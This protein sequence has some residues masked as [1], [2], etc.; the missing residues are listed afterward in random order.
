MKN[1]PI[2]RDLE[3][4]SG[5]TW[6]ALAE[7]EPKLGELLWAARQAG[8]TC[9]CWADVDRAFA[10][11]LNALPEMVGL[12]GK[13]YRHPVLGQLPAYYVAYWRLYDAVAGL[14]PGRVGGAEEA[15]A[16][17]CGETVA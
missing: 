1:Y 15:P 4:L 12:T 2:Y 8:I 17:Q 6:R 11:I 5:I 16:K 7:L 9:R 14:L 3:R 10:A 13:N